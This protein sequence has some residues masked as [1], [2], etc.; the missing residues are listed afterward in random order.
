[1]TSTPVPASA[2]QQAP[3]H[4]TAEELARLFHRTYERMGREYGKG[5]GLKWEQTDEDYRALLVDVFAEL[6]IAL[7]PG[8]TVTQ[9]HQGD[10]LLLLLS[11]TVDLPDGEKDAHDLLQ[12]V[13]ALFPDNR[14]CLLLGTE[15]G[16]TIPAPD[17]NAAAKT[18]VRRSPGL[19]QWTAP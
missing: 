6:E 14:V 12:S 19:P 10:T 4:D 17:G 13:Q 18:P 16:I 5:Q 8:R 1:M 9:L 15:Q 11:G 7:R 2:P 3:L